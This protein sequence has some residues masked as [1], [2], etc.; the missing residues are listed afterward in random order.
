MKFIQLVVDGS[1][2]YIAQ[3]NINYISVS[4]EKDG[5]VDI[6]LNEQTNFTF[7]KFE[8]GIE[9]INFKKIRQVILDWMTIDSIDGMIWINPNSI[10]CCS[11][12]NA[13]YTIIFKNGCNLA[14]VKLNHKGYF[15]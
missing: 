6:V 1:K 2:I 13:F 4:D 8:Y 14:N 10:G 7:S 5:Y 12:V 3:D 15:S 11:E 9:S